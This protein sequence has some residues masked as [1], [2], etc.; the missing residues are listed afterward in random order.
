MHDSPNIFISIVNIY[1]SLYDFN[2]TYISFWT[3]TYLY[4]LKS[5]ER[6]GLLHNYFISQ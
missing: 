5:E 3:S 6:S 1:N 4:L 2:F